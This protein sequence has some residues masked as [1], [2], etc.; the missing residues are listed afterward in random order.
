MNK[1]I[2]KVIIENPGV[3]GQALSLMTGISECKISRYKKILN[4]CPSTKP[5]DCV[6]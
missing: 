4:I 3:D 6:G 5:E 1:Y 2:A